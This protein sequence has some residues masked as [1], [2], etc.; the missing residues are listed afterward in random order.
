M[1][2][3]SFILL[4]SD[5]IPFPKQ[6]TKLVKHKY[7][8][9]YIQSKRSNMTHLHKAWSES[10]SWSPPWE[11]IYAPTRFLARNVSRSWRVTLGFLFWFCRSY[12]VRWTSSGRQWTRRRCSCWR[13][14][15]LW[16]YT[17]CCSATEGEK[18]H[19]W[20]LSQ[21]ANCLK[22]ETK[23][24]CILV[25]VS[26][27]PCDYYQT[28]ALFLTPKLKCSSC[29]VLGFHKNLIVKWWMLGVR[30]DGLIVRGI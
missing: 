28:I 13:G 5:Q 17:R 16:T 10:A 23:Q 4:P 8:N 9:E 6:N 30:R 18:T 11:S 3:A 21:H 20:G 7:K 22:S 19:T 25:E 15:S 24:S 1:C 27:V 2:R 12:S 26:F 29:Y 14:A